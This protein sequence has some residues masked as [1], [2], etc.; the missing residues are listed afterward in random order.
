M[1]RTWDFVLNTKDGKIKIW[2]KSLFLEHEQLS[3]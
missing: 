1:A 2:L 3:S